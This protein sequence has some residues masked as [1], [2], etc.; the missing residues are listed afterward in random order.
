[1][2]KMHQNTFGGRADVPGPAVAALHC[3]RPASRS[4]G[5]YFKRREGM[6]VGLL[7]G[8]REERWRKGRG[9]L[10]QSQGE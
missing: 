8:G 1:M 9:E 7:L 2:R 4:D 5:A 6:G 10:P 3:A